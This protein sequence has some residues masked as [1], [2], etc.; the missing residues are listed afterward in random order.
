[1]FIVYLFND[2]AQNMCNVERQYD[3]YHGIGKDIE[4]SGPY[5]CLK[6]NSRQTST[7]A[8]DVPVVTGQCSFQGFNLV[9]GG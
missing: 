9:Y 7:I 1:M 6:E 3:D 2:A 4:G 5:L 8:A